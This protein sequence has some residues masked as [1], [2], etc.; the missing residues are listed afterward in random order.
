MN[1]SVKPEF[2]FLSTVSFVMISFL[3]LGFAIGASIA[4][5][6]L[7]RKKP[8][9]TC[10]KNKTSPM[11]VDNIC[12]CTNGVEAIQDACLSNND[13]MCTS[14]NSGFYLSADSCSE[15]MCSCS[16]GTGATG[17][18]C[19]S[20]GISLCTVCDSGYYLRNDLCVLATN[21]NCT[22][23]NGVAAVRSADDGLEVCASC[24]NG[25]YTQ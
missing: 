21:N 25:Y 4:A 10:F 23:G 13:E 12:S 5:V 22:C 18:N 9:L 3:I 19:P 1:N 6:C 24:D 2:V 20:N 16:H 14:C 8:L 17:E 7:T 15:N 11:D